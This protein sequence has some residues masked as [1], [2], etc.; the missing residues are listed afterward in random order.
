[1]IAVM[2][3]LSFVLRFCLFLDAHS[4]VYTTV[5]PALMICQLIAVLEVL[6]PLLGWVRTGVLMTL[7]QVWL[8]FFLNM[9]SVFCLF[10]VGF[11]K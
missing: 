5:G 9:W 11:F 2:L 4:E 10:F 8:N 7:I 3:R 1:V 6:H